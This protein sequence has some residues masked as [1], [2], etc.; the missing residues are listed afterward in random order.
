MPNPSYQSSRLRKRRRQYEKNGQGRANLHDSRNGSRRSPRCR[1]DKT[2][3][4]PD[5]PTLFETHA[6]IKGRKAQVDL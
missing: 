5:S 1:A 6:Q 3:K 4:V 2:Q